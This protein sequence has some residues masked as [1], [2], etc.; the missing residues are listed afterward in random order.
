M[1]ANQNNKR[2]RVKFTGGAKVTL[3]ALS[4]ISFVGGW[5][6]I[7][8]LD[9]KEAQASPPSP[10]D[11]QNQL[12]LPVAT[13]WPT[14]PPLPNFA[15]VPTLVPTQTT[16]QLSDSPQPQR[17]GDTLAGSANAA[18]LQIAPVP[19]LVPLPT[20]APLP[21]MPQLPPPPPPPPVQTWNGGGG[22]QSGGS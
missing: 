6:L 14:I 3:A 4:M 22:N 20:L 2:K 5:D 18:P 9:N 21:A 7:A 12:L 11:A 16:A 13:P 19:T 10:V 17:Q 1:S 15:P 8:R